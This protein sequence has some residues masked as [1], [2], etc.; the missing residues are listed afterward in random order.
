MNKYERLY[1]SFK[2]ALWLARRAKFY[3]AIELMHYDAKE[4]ATAAHEKWS[5]DWYQHWY[6]A[7][8]VIVTAPTCDKKIKRWFANRGFVF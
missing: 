8:G 7:L 3:H 2:D 6:E 1:V 5:D 4:M